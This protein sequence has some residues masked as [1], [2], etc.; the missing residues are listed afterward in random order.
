M[1]K[2]DSVFSFLSD[3]L[4]ANVNTTYIRDTILKCYK[5]IFV[6]GA[7]KTSAITYTITAQFRMLSEQLIRRENALASRS[8]LVSAH[9][10][11]QTSLKKEYQASIIEDASITYRVISRDIMKGKVFSLFSF[12]TLLIGPLLSQ[13]IKKEE[14]EHMFLGLLDLL[15]E[16]V[17][18]CVKSDDTAL[19][20]AVNRYAQQHL[21]MVRPKLKG[22]EALLKRT[23]ELAKKITSK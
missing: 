19:I 7:E 11:F 15:E 4:I 2:L 18:E 13:T 9:D 23:T 17:T 1:T 16:Y 21:D 10:L 14:L 6:M 3:L 20:R 22:R 12:N 8:L 5:E